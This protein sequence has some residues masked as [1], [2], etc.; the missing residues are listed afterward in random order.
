MRGLIRRSFIG[1]LALAFAASGAAWSTCLAAQQAPIAPVAVHHAHDAS[2]H[3]EHAGHAHHHGDRG[4][5]H[6]ATT[7]EPSAPAADDHG[8][9]K[10]CSICTM[11][12]AVPASAAAV[13]L[14]AATVVFSSEPDDHSA[15]AVRVD[16]G[17]P[18]RSA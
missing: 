8:C 1:L 6:H 17:I 2:A 11:T 12:A 7:D 4:A 5:I 10:C 16:P 14:I 15:H 18:K 9:V 13:S 3:H